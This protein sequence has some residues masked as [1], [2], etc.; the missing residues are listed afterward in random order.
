MP[1]LVLESLAMLEVS[2]V[3]GVVIWIE[4]PDVKVYIG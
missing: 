2:I 1:E 3:E 4:M